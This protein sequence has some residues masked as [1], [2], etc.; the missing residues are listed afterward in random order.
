MS[1][2]DMVKK[3]YIL[4]LSLSLAILLP[5]CNDDDTGIS[6]APLAGAPGTLTVTFDSSKVTKSTESDASENLIKNVTLALYVDGADENAE[7]VY[8]GTYPDLNANSRTS[9]TFYLTNAMVEQLFSTPGYTKCRIYAVANLPGSSSIPAKPTIAQLKA[10]AVSSPFAD[11]AVQE[12][13]VMSGLG[14]I[15]Y[16]APANP[17]PGN[18]G[19]A[20]GSCTLN[21]AAAKIS[22]NVKLPES[23]T[24]AN[25]E[26]VDETWLPVAG[27]GN[28]IAY[29]NNGVQN[30]IAYPVN[31]VG[32]PAWKPTS[33]A[34]YYNSDPT[35][36]VSYR[37]F[38][39]KGS[40][41]ESEEVIGPDGTATTQN[42]TYSVFGTD[43]PY[44][45]YPNAWSVNNYEDTGQTTLTLIVRWRK[46][47]ESLQWTNYYYQVP[48]TP[49]DIHQI[50]A[51]HS[52]TINLKVGMLGSLVPERPLEVEGSYQV[53]NWSTE[54]VNVDIND[55]RYLVVNPNNIAV[56]NEA[57]VVIPFY[58]SHEVDIE[59][60]TMT[61]QRF[62]FYS[63]GN[64]EVVDIEIPQAKID[65]SV[66]GDQKMVSY[67]I[68]TDAVTNQKSLKINHPLEIWTAVNNA[69]S[70]ITNNNTVSFTNH[71]DGT[72][73]SVVNSINHFNRPANPEAPYSPYVFKV[74]IQHNDKPSFYEDITITQYPDMY[75]KADAN[76]GGTYN[77]GYRR[78]SFTTSAYGN[79]F[80][81]PTWT[82][83][84]NSGY[85]T[86][87]STL[88]SVFGLTGNGN[89]N[90][91]M[92][93]INISQMDET[94]TYV[95]GDPRTLYSNNDLEGNDDLSNPTSDGAIAG[96]WC[97]SAQSIYDNQNRK[98][99]YYY[100]TIESQD[101]QYKMRV[102]P[103]F[104]IASSYGITNSLRREN[105]RRRVATYQEQKCPA[106]RWRLPT[107]GELKFITELSST[108][109]IPALFN[110]GVP[111][112]T[113]QGAYTVNND[114]TLTSSNSTSAYVRGV[115]DEWYWEQYPQYSGTAGTYQLGDMPKQSN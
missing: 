55:Y 113:A 38:I 100:P 105:A 42:V 93:V 54:T 57:E 63:N 14:Q 80:V 24:V 59:N 66:S 111:Y 21:R 72:L 53:M 18:P 25:S 30:S 61:F 20:S 75:I 6:D 3:L 43:V 79:V 104:R 112:W 23:I 19:T 102:T 48:V 82:A 46:Q 17:S 7:P 44:Y 40:T 60:L 9:V 73:K 101:N 51:N 50:D 83:Q 35:K 68:V 78:G 36:A 32:E 56:Q 34:D 114:G 49:T 5:G 76:P 1:D 58:T 98:L 103:K 41:T 4:F 108:G 77:T 94:S 22:L 67:E 29:I 65:A 62:N 109:K 11:T 33:S 10:I 64:G 90:P 69:S 13:F 26:G 84:G 88:G 110:S 45:T 106:G 85:W 86:N 2:T 71:N 91:N 37:S 92:Y 15:T 81:N 107:Y 97:N 16:S 12:S 8:V 99:K 52:Y 115:Y 31:A 96:N 39:G 95:I 87:S 74:K 47:G 27:E 28:L 70:S 89:K